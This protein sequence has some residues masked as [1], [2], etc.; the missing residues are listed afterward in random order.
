MR[1]RR[2]TRRLLLRRQSLLA[3]YHDELARATEE[4]D[5][6]EIEAI[7]NA[8]E[9]WDAKILSRLSEVDAAML[10]RVTAA[11]RRLEDGTYGA[12][13]A[14]GVAIEAPRLHALP[15]AETCYDCACDQERQP[16][17]RFAL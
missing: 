11:L 13:L 15:E 14:C 16:A 2:T 9:L 4:L 7:E 8:T 12:C 1:T 5:S 6:R 10:G 17:M 3:R